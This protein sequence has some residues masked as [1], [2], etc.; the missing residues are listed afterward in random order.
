MLSKYSK[1][2]HENPLIDKK[3]SSSNEFT[4]G[5]HPYFA[6]FHPDIPR[7]IIKLLAKPGM[8]ILD[9]F[10]GVGTTLVESIMSNYDC[11][12]IDINPLAILISRVKT[13]RLDAEIMK[14][15]RNVS[16]TINQAY[17][18]KVKK[19]KD[20]YSFLN[21]SPGQIGQS[22][23]KSWIPS[24]PNI[25]KWFKK[26]VISELS[27][28]IDIINR[29]DEPK[30]KDFCNVALSRIIIR[31]SNQSGESRYVSVSKEYKIGQATK[32]FIDHINYM[33][34][35][36][37]VLNR[38]SAKSRTIQGDTRNSGI[39]IEDD[40]LDLLVTSPP[41]LNSW[42]YNLYHRF[43][44]F[45]LGYT[46]Q[47]LKTFYEKEIGPHLRSQRD[48]EDI[49]ERYTSDMTSCF[50]LFNRVLKHEK[51]AIG[52]VNAP[53]I[54]K[55]EFLDTNDIIIDI[56]K[57][58]NFKIKKIYTK[59]VFGPHIGLDASKETRNLKMET[60]KEKKEAILIFER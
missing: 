18:Q 54:V 47:D 40:S 35:K 38:S 14:E 56:A 32:L 6:K 27:S 5:F 42:D 51:A 23:E 29:I 48:K 44:F 16:S 4:H 15:I 59:A 58:F 34:A 13:T 50:K 2:I 55:K 17:M 7:F 25:D 1:I 3:Y 9:P 37:D 57:E 30:I 22:T 8:R 52:L 24:I 43:R 49:V 11:V 19:E 33:L 39:E 31:V 26:D 20:L 21:K 53:S 36:I 46:S 28:I 60:I 45:W 41:Y 10:C 12:G